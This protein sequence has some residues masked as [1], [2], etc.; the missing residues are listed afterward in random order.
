LR[1]TTPKIFRRPHRREQKYNFKSLKY[2]Q[3]YQKKRR[4]QFVA[5]N[6]ELFCMPDFEIVNIRK[7]KRKMTIAKYN[8]VVFHRT[9][10]TLVIRNH[11]WKKEKK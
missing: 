8:K 11:S 5:V 9:K 3:I 10:Y 4:R 2:R 7:K 1:F 6:Y